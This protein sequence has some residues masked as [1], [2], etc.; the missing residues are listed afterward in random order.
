MN[1]IFSQRV[2]RYY[3]TIP[4]AQKEYIQQFEKF[5]TFK[6]L[7]VNEII[8]NYFDSGTD[9]EVLLLLHGGFVEESIHLAR[10]SVRFV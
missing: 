2:N 7:R 4:C 10:V 1:Q 5:H 6:S 9:A 8:W 3:R